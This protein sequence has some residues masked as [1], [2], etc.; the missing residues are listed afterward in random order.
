M[1]YIGKAFIPV[2]LINSISAI[3]AYLFHLSVS[4]AAS[5]ICPGFSFPIFLALAIQT[6]PICLKVLITHSISFMMISFPSVHLCALALALSQ[7][8]L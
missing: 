1:L 4:L 3:P 6:P 7:L 2:T 8:T 5:A